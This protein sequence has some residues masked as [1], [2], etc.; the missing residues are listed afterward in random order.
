M[1]VLQYPLRTY[2]IE[3][4]NMTSSGSYSG[5]DVRLDFYRMQAGDIEKLEV[6]LKCMGWIK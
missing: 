1:T 4:V 2:S 6:F 3:G 5:F